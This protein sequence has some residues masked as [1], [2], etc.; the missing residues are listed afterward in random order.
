MERLW[1]WEKI[2]AK[3]EYLRNNMVENKEYHYNNKG[4]N[5]VQVYRKSSGSQY[6]NNSPT[7]N[8]NRNP[9]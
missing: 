3:N 5:Q 6:S 7:L 4:I 9:H 2:N 1:E 8:K